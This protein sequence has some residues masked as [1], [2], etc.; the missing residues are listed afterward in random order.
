M[1]LNKTGMFSHPHDHGSFDIS[2]VYYVDTTGEDG[3]LYFLN[4]NKMMKCSKI[5]ENYE[6][7]HFFKP[8]VG[9][10]FLFPS[11][12][13]HGVSE[14]KTKSDRISLSFNIKVLPI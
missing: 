2:G 13:D 6:Q 7:M 11:W 4:P 8:E 14:N 1:T 5:T 12:L 10:L 3:N 9:R